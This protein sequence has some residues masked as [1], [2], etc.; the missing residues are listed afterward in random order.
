MLAVSNSESYDLGFAANLPAAGATP[1]RADRDS[2]AAHVRCRGPPESSQLRSQRQLLGDW[3]SSVQDLLMP[4]RKWRRTPGSGEPRSQRGG[5]TALR[6]RISGGASFPREESGR[7]TR[8]GF[9]TQASATTSHR[10]KGSWVK[11]TR[12]IRGT[13]E[14]KATE[15]ESAL[16]DYASR[17]GGRGGVAGSAEVSLSGAMAGCHEVWPSR[18]AG[19]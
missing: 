14:A 12:G 16:I 4:I 7:E 11:G 5:E 3:E 13:R 19:R 15:R 2:C 9:E 1:L 6:Y 17:G 10:T 8:A 18:R